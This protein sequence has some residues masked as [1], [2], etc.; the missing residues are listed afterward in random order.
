MFNAKK[1]LEEGKY[2]KAEE[3]MSRGVER[4]KVDVVVRR[5][6]GDRVQLYKLIDDPTMLPA[7]EWSRVAA[8]FVTGQTWQF[9][10]WR[11]S[12]PVQLFQ[13][14]LATHLMLEG[15]PVDPTVQSWNCRVLKVDEFK[16]YVNAGVASQFW[17]F[18]DDFLQRKKPHL[19]HTAAPASS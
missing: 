12:E 8:V 16:D 6:A 3:A 18:L 5:M 9:S 15:R 11:E 13:Q 7:E 1:F 10:R 2:V 19:A 17:L 14:V 4:K